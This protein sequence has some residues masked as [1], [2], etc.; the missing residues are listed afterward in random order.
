[1]TK[2]TITR[3]FIGSLIAIAGG[4]VLL[5]VTGGAAYANGYFVMDGPD[6]VGIRT[7]PLGWVLI[8]L[9]ALAGLALLAAVIAQFVAWIAAV[10]NAAQLPDKTWFLVLLVTGL[11][12]FGLIGMIVYLVAAPDS[13]RPAAPRP[14]Q[15]Q[16]PAA[17]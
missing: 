5:G 6:V 7:T 11:L 10:I 2:H 1:M 17:A 12:S 14:Q 15:P 8:G 4:L 3:L 16:F 9:A 13:Q